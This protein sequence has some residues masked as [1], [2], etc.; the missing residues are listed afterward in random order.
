MYFGW[1]N[2]SSIATIVMLLSLI[3]IAKP[4]EAVRPLGGAKPKYG[5]KMASFSHTPTPPSAPNPCTNI[6]SPPTGHCH[7]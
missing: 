7:K 4:H 3:F 1:K 6:P 5:P 2:L